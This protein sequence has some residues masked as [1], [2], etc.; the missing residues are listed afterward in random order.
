MA[1]FSAPIDRL[2]VPIRLDPTL[3]HEIGEFAGL[4]AGQR[5][6][7]YRLECARRIAEAQIDLRRIRQV[8]LSMWS[9]WKI[10]DAEPSDASAEAPKSGPASALSGANMDMNALAEQL[11]RL[12]R[13]ERRALSRRKAATRKIHRL[14]AYPPE[15][16]RGQLRSSRPHVS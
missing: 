12:D 1:Y 14:G 4:I 6:P 2:A 11:L 10:G 16:G 15:V 9:R 8:R 3:I 13:Y 7:P 5:A